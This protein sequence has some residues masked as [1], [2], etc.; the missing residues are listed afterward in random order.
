MLDF[1]LWKQIWLWALTL[2]A[3][4]ASVPTLVTQFGGQWPSMLPN[5][6]VSLGLDLA[7]GSYLLLEAQASDVAKQRLDGMAETARTKMNDAKIRIGDVSTADGKVT[8][9]LEDPSQVDA[10]RQALLP[11]MNGAGT[12]REWD[13]NV[14]NGNTFVLTLTQKGLDEDVKLAMASATDVVRKRINA[15]G[16]KEPTIVQEGSNRIMVQVP[17]LQN[18]QQLKDLL[19]KTAELSF[20]LVDTTALQSD[21]AQGIVPPGDQIVPCIDAHACGGAA[22]LAVKR[23]GGIRGDELT[24]A[25][26]TNKSQTNEPVVSIQFN[27]Q[28]AEKFARLTTENTNKPF[29]IILDGQVISAPNINEPILGGSAIIEGSFTTQSANDLAIQ[30]NSGALPVKLTVV[31]QSTVSAELGADS[32]HKGAV[33]MIVGAVI[34][35][36]LIAAAYGRF[37]IYADLAVIINVIMILGIMAVFGTTLTLPGIAGFV[38]TIGASVDANVLINERI[39]EERRRGRKAFQAV[40]LGYTEASRTIFD[41]NITHGIAATLMFMF[42]SGPIKGFA[43]VLMIGIVTSVFTAIY[44]TRMWVALWLRRARPADLNI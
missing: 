20:K 31:D 12:V 35:V 33:A 13:L 34:I 2:L 15:F 21:L 26:Q 3:A 42:G 8:F 43:V 10:A 22:S 27:S 40:D 19:G 36:I 1:P 9:M 4:F 14:L 28:G 24:K 17:G 37:G 32:I 39:R 29:A 23:L 5:P 7:G 38:L 41:A 18:P 16:T 6:Q 11:A 44:L 25:Q 30:L